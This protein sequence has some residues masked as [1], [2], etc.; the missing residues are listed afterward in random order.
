MPQLAPTLLAHP[1]IGSIDAGDLDRSL[2]HGALLTSPWGAL[3]RDTPAPNEPRAGRVLRA[4]VFD[5]APWQ[6]CSGEVACICLP[7]FASARLPA[8]G[9][10]FLS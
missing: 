9:T 6:I 8:F 2:S 4:M 10:M 7:C 3:F 1:P 5:P